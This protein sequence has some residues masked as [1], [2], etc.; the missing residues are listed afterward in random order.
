[1]SFIFAQFC[2]FFL[3]QT[4][5]LKYVNKFKLSHLYIYNNNN[6]LNISLNLD[7]NS[8]MVLMRTFHFLKSYVEELL[9]MP[10]AYENISIGGGHAKF[11]FVSPLATFCPPPLKTSFKKN[12]DTFFNY[13]NYS[14]YTLPY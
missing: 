8:C 12:I 3:L 13:V 9:L 10:G 6:N 2:V 4:L 5:H 14:I 1:M 11:F 7:Q